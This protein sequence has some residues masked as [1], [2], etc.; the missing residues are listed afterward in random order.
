[1]SEQPPIASSADQTKSSRLRS[2]HLLQIRR[3]ARSRAARAQMDAARAVTRIERAIF[4]CVILAAVAGTTTLVV[5]SYAIASRVSLDF[6]VM[7]PQ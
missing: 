5:V 2:L 4:F 7:P 6:A 3:D 1:M